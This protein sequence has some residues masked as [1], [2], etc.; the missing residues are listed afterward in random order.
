MKSQLLSTVSHELRTPLASIKGYVTTLIDYR[1]RLQADT[2]EEFLR[3]IDSES[4]RLQELVENLLDMSRIEAG[5]L[6]IHPEPT[7]LTP[8][9]ERALAVLQPKLEGREVGVDSLDA[10]P[11]VMIDSTRV[12]QVLSN[13]IDNATKYSAPG[14]PIRVHVAADQAH[15]TVGVQDRGPGIAPEHVERIF[16]RFYR[17][18][19][20]G[21]RSTGGIGLGLAIC[22]GLIEAHGGRLW[23][24]SVLGE[25]STF[26]FSIPVAV[27]QA[28]PPATSDGETSE[29]LEV[30]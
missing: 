29:V 5:V 16:D 23:V 1:E 7:R 22:R 14:S 28:E 24:A 12:Q 3:I 30:M 27:V 9:V 15:V 13:L 18:E 19:D 20:A 11:D 6:R 25:G 17:I 26:Y 2:Q 10:L 8:V 4:D 21:I